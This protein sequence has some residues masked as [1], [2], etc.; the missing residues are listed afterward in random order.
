MTQELPPPARLMQIM[1]ASILSQAT[2]AAAVLGVA[3]ALRDGP[4][5]AEELARATG[6]HP[7]AL[8]RLLRALATV[9][10]FTEIEGGRF[11]LT[12]T[13]ACLRSDA[14]PSLRDMVVMMGSPWRLRAWEGIVH[15]IKTAEA[16]FGKVFGVGAFDYFRAHPEAAEVFHRSMVSYTSSI[17]PVV[18]RV[19]DFSGCHK[20]VDIAGGH[21]YL[22][23]TILKAHPGLRGVLFDLPEAVRD[24]PRLL[25]REGVADRCEVVGGDF[26]QSVAPGGDVYL[27]KQIIHDWDD[28]KA[29]AIL[30]S[31]RE[32]LARNGRVL[33]IESVVPAGNGPSHAKLLDLEVLVA[34]GGERRRTE[35]ETEELLAS[36]GLRLNRVIPTEVGIEIVEAVAA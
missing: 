31:C 5:T 13:G 7:G 19:S 10:V 11:Q 20:V 21:G 3:D 2:Y 22:L 14:S 17:A 29:R 32:V 16:A 33:L 6:A 12:P 35:E 26:F 9:D 34:L 4:R 1:T 27:L 24:A 8:Y 15:S 36:A 25:E 30:A 23:A 18:A 28:G